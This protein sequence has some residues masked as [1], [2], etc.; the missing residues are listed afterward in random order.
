MRKFKK[1]QFWT[2][3]ELKPKKTLLPW[4]NAVAIASINLAYSVIIGYM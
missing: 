3:R 2:F 4:R 1:Q